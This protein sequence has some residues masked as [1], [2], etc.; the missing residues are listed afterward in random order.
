[1]NCYNTYHN[2]INHIISACYLWYSIR[3][4]SNY[5]LSNTLLFTINNSIIQGNTRY[6]DRFL[7]DTLQ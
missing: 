1:M 2:S 6:N 5:L 7:S 4:K 3:Y